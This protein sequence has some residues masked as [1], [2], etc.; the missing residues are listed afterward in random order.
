MEDAGHDS[1]TG[2]RAWWA[3]AVLGLG[4]VPALAASCEDIRAQVDAKLRAS[5]VA[6]YSLTVVDSA[7]SA[8]GRTVGTCD[9]GTRKIVYLQTRAGADP[10]AAAPKAAQPGAAGI[11]TECRD[12]RVSVGGDCRK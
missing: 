4:S 2:L 11:I 12:G 10:A 6:K 8:A 3:A 5:G 1:S 9:L 7:A